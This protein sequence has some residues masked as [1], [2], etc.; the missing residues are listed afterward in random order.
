MLMSQI[1]INNEE[2]LQSMILFLFEKAKYY[3]S[4]NNSQ[5]SDNYIS[6]ANE[7]LK[8]LKKVSDKNADINNN[9]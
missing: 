1:S 8:R 2:Y 4:N 9:Q 7:Y 6:L 5:L 3:K